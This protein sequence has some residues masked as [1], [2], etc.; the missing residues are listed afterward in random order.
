MNYKFRDGNGFTL[1]EAIIGLGMI[2]IVGI[3]ILQM[4]M[5][6]SKVNVRAADINTAQM[7]AVNTIEEMRVGRCP[8][9]IFDT[10]FVVGS[11][12]AFG[13]DS[14]SVVSSRM[15]LTAFEFVS[16]DFTLVKYYNED[17]QPVHLETAENEPHDPQNEYAVFKLELRLIPQEGEFEDAI[18]GLFDVSVYIWDLRRSDIDDPVVYFYTKLYFPMVGE[19]I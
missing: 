9:A 3:L 4:F 10:E 14:F 12:F 19:L 6:A 11:Q 18:L 5:V 17:W 16:D 1:L 13:R 7:I 8:N 15:G 2:A